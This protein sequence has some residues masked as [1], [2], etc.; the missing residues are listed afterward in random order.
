MQISRKA[1]DRYRLD[2]KYFTSSGDLYFD[3][4]PSVRSFI[5]LINKNRDILNF[6]ELAVRTSEVN[7]IAVM[8]DVF[9]HIIDSYKQQENPRVFFKFLSRIK[10]DLPENEIDKTLQQFIDDFPPPKVHSGKITPQ[11]Y[12]KNREKG[13]NNTITTLE[14]MLKLWLVNRNP[15]NSRFREFSESNT[16]EKT[17]IYRKIIDEMRDFFSKEPLFGP[18]D[19]DLITM[20]SSV[21]ENSPK[22]ISEQL[23][24]VLDRWGSYL[25]DKYY[26]VLLA[27]DLYKEEEKFRGTGPGESRVIDF[28]GLGIENYTSDRDWMPNVVMIAKNTYVWLDQLSKKYKRDIS[29]L[30]QI[31]DE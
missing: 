23:K 10:K 3:D 11:D 2:N 8:Q 12:L 15:A 1:R 24:Y 7:G 27:I 18:D 5:Q 20:L 22:S 25:G 29:K 28:D 13:L 16:L 30:D 26:N 21:A 6:P 9:D 17:T 4:L 31:P 19:Q 14:R